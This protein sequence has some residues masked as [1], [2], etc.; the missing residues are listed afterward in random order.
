MRRPDEQAVID[1]FVSFLE[2]TTGSKWTASNDKVPNPNNSRR[3]D[4]EFTSTGYRPVAADIFRL[5]SLGSD[6]RF[7]VPDAHS[8]R[9]ESSASLRV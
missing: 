7:R 4:C 9:P 3:Y 8:S 5:Y 1:C 6:Q 2:R